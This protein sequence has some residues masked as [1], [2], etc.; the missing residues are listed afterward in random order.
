LKDALLAEIRANKSTLYSLA[1]A[2]A[3]RIDVSDDKVTFTFAPNQK[4]AR[5]QLEQ[6]ADWI[7]DAVQRLSGRRLPVTVVQSEAAGAAPSSPAAAPERTP[8]ESSSPK[9]DLRSEAMAS[10]AVQAML[11]VFPGEIRDVEEI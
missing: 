2:M 5:N 6:N 4:V 8:E 11:D 1:I 10:P 7:A 9:R 3:S